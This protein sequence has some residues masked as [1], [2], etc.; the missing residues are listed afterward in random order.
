[1]IV[2]HLTERGVIDPELLYESPFTDVSDQGLSGV[3]PA[4]RSAK[5]MEIVRQIRATAAA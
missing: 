2:N 1:M 3:F 4:E 5:V